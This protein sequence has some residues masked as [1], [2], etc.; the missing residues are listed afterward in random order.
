MQD[1]STPAR[2]IKYGHVGI[3]SNLCTFFTSGSFASSF[4]CASLRFSFS[5]RF[6]FFC[7]FAI[8]SRLILFL[9]VEGSN[10]TG[11]ILSRGG[12][13][14]SARAWKSLQ[15]CSADERVQKSEAWI[16]R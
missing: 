4:A 7:L 10:R 5:C 1:V 13:S 2:L 8:S 15:L 11:G 14:R 12:E 9:I 3:M 6:V 16:W